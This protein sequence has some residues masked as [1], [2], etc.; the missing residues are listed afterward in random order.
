VH[1]PLLSLPRILGM[2]LESIPADI[3]TF[4]LIRT[5]SGTGSSN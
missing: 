3:P 5:S 2:T 1:A 4:S